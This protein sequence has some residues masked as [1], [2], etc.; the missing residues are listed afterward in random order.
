MREILDVYTY[1]NEILNQ[2]GVLR[3]FTGGFIILALIIWTAF[4]LLLTS[5]LIT[6]LWNITV[7]KIFG[8]R[9]IKFWEGFRLVLI[10]WLLMGKLFEILPYSL[11]F[12]M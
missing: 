4:I 7:T 2:P 6:W 11:F 12:S 3:F 10:V 5:A 1:R 8:I 9:E